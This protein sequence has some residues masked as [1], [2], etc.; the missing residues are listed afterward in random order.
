MRYPERFGNVLS[1]SGAFWWR[2]ER[3]PESEWLARQL[4]SGPTLPLRFYLDAGL[5]EKWPSW[6]FGPSILISNRHFRNVLSA[7]GY[8][9]Y[10]AEFNGGHNDICWQGT[11]ADGLMALLPAGRKA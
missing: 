6:D 1:Q 3:D 2:P 11:L 4:A 10:Y 7:K 8:S 5:M 9:M